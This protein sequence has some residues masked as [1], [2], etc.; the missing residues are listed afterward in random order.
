MAVTAETTQWIRSAF[1]TGTA[2]GGAEARFQQLIDDVLVPGLR[3]LPG[4][5][6]VS[7][8]WPRNLEDSPP[9]IACQV[10]V[11]FANRADVERMLSSEERRQLRPQVMEAVALFDGSISH[12]EFVTSAPTG[13]ATSHPDL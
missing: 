4:V 7:A 1:W 8:L 10:L 5:Q 6:S 9:A 2:K 3:A 11:A 12:I 13:A